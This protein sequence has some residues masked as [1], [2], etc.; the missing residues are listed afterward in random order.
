[1]ITLA[2]LILLPSCKLP[3]ES[4][5]YDDKCHPEEDSWLAWAKDTTHLAANLPTSP[6]AAYQDA[7][8]EV[9]RLG[10][11][12]VQKTEIGSETWDGFATTFPGT[13][14]LGLNWKTLGEADRA[15][16]LRHEIVHKKQWDALGP[17]EFLRRYMS[18]EG[19]WSLEVPAH[20]E[21]FRVYRA[22]GVKEKTLAKMRENAIDSF[23]E[24]YFLQDRMP[25]CTKA[26]TLEIWEEDAR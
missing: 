9:E 20:R 11:R 18:P 7:L 26:L 14:F 10:L 3:L 12:L 6:E 1:M 25:E 16:T 21:D 2:S 4:V 23:Y 5:S 19:R 17:Q 24:S 13:V 22:L 15:A 8:Q